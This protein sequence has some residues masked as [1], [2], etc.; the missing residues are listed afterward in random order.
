MTAKSLFTQV[1]TM[2]TLRKGE[3]FKRIK[4]STKDDRKAIRKLVDSGWSYCDKQTWKKEC[5]DK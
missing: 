2:M 3:E 5:R 4:D 1:K